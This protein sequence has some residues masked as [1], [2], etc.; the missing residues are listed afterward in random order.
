MGG[1]IQH[2]QRIRRSAHSGAGRQGQAK[3]LQ[4]FAATRN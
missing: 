4:S 1:Q 2:L 3:M